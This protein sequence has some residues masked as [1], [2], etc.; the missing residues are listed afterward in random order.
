MNAMAKVQ[1]LE[2]GAGPKEKVKDWYTKLY[3]KSA[4]YELPEEDVRQ[5]LYELEA[6]YN[7]FLAALKNK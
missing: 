6:A 4:N 2:P 7:L 5:L 1:S 3:Q